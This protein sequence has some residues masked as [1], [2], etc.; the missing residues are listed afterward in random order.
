MLNSKLKQALGLI[1]SQGI[2]TLAYKIYKKGIYKYYKKKLTDFQNSSIS[3]PMIDRFKYVELNS[4]D[5]DD[6]LNN[7]LMVS[8]ILLY[9]GEQESLD[10]CLESI[11]TR[12]TYTNFEI[13]IGTFVEV[14]DFI[15]N[16]YQRSIIKIIFCNNPFNYSK[17][18]NAAVNSAEGQYLVLL[19]DLDQIV[20][21]NWIEELF[22]SAS[23]QDEV[24]VV[25]AL[26]SSA[27]TVKMVENA[28][29]GSAIRILALQEI[30]RS[31][32]MIKTELF[33][34]NNGLNHYFLTSYANI[35][36]CMRISES[37][38][39]V[40]YSTTNLFKKIHSD[41]VVV[42]PMDKALFL[43]CWEK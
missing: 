11:I 6:T 33:T 15:L 41:E 24:G 42:N 4:H 9:Q 22:Y 16:K 40:L 38:E 20:R 3:F 29:E 34:K 28:R 1:K 36:L 10:Q 19:S 5:T 32:L 27:N 23:S 2:K 35:D 14:G 12:S 43:N 21:H 26:P 7:K 18:I 39:T 37:G 13:I 25:I 17:A 8:I 31:C 30:S